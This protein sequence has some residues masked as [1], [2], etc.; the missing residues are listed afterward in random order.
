[1]KALVSTRKGLL[2]LGKNGQVFTVDKVHFEG[3]KVSIAEYNPYNGNIWAGINHDRRGPKLHLSRDDGRKFIEAPTPAFAKDEG[4]ALVD[5]GDFGFDKTGRIYIGTL[6]AALF[7]SDDNGE[8]WNQL[9]SLSKIN[10]FESWSG[11]K[12]NQTCLHSILINPD[13]DNHVTVGIP[14]A[15][16]IESRDRGQTWNYANK[17]LKTYFLPDE[18]A[19]AIQDPHLLVRSKSHPEIIWQ[20]NH[21]GIFK[22]TDHG[23]SWSDLS[24]A[25][26][27]TSPFGFSIAVDEKDPDIA[28][29]IPVKS[30][31]LRVPVDNTL[32]IQKTT[33]GGKSFRSI[34]EGLPSGACFDISY[35]HAFD[36]KKKTLAFGTTTGNLYFSHDSGESWRQEF[37]H[38]PPIYAL[39]LF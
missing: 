33:D 26:G 29:T 35:R 32:Y 12:A 20:Q 10:G 3:V 37:A 17:G 11:G 39:R 36:L 34:C 25:S 1:M 38:L 18:D 22:S 31:E 14:C 23:A 5:F 30:D 16:V 27:L 8:S 6:P 13:D 24:K 28:Y 9:S 4:L 19:T 15:G 21:C 2:I 7:Y